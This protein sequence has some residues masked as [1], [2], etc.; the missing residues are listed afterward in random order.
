MKKFIAAVLAGI[1][2]MSLA[3]CG[4]TGIAGAGSNWVEEDDNI[5]AYKYDDGTYLYEGREGSTMKTAWF[6]FTVNGAYYTEDSIGG[7]TPSNGNIL[8]VVDLTLKNTFTESVPMWQDDFVLL[9][10]EEVDDEYSYPVEVSE[11]LLDD[12]FPYEFNMKVNETVDG[13]LIFEAPA[14]E[15]D[16]SIAFIEYYE[17]NSEGDAFR[18]YFSADEK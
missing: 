4:K 7:Y 1:M 5:E 14:G 6:D 8:V 17:D 10:T 3:A 13:L 16:F 15:E 11:S 12:Q 9:W 2:M 18:V